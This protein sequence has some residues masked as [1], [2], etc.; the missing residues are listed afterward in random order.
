MSAIRLQRGGTT[1]GSFLSALGCVRETRLTATLGFLISRFPQEFLPLLKMT[2]RGD[3]E[4]CVE[5]TTEGDRYDILLRR[6]EAPVVLEGKTGLTQRLDQLKR[7]ARSLRR[8]YGRRPGL[9]VVDSGSERSLGLSS[10]HEVLK[11]LV[12][13]IGHVTWT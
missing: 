5:E 1:V 10:A 12:D 6:G 9:V 3:L 8:E 7:Y 4:V 11:P 13:G 2:Q